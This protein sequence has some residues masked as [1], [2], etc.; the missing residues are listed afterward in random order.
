MVNR[1]FGYTMGDV[2]ILPCP[3]PLLSIVRTLLRTL[4]CTECYGVRS[5]AGTDEWGTYLTFACG[6]C[7]GGHDPADRSMG[8]RRIGRVCSMPVPSVSSLDGLITIARFA[9]RA[10]GCNRQVL[11][12]FRTCVRVRNC[13]VSWHQTI[14]P[15]DPD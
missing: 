4:C 13:M 1:L 6:I 12:A 11:S 15:T 14:G 9:S 2:W 8:S 5:T 10:G 3:P 7:E